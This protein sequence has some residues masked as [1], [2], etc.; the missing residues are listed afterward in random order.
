MFRIFITISWDRNVVKLYKITVFF[1][2]CTECPYVVL[3]K[4]VD[5]IT[6][7][8]SANSTVIRLTYFRIMG[9]L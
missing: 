3:K 7:H 6:L 8:L 2:N 1:K 5:Y 9:K 4:R